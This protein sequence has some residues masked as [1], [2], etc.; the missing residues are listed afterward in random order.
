MKSK[1]AREEAREEMLGLADRLHEESVCTIQYA[2][3]C[4]SCRGNRIYQ[5]LDHL[6]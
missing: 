1:K 4:S 2:D 3:I 6:P 5:L